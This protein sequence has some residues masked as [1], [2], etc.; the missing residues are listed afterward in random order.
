MF[1]KHYFAKVAVLTYMIYMSIWVIKSNQWA[2]FWVWYCLLYFLSAELTVYF[3]TVLFYFLDKMDDSDLWV[4][5][6]KSIT[7]EIP[8]IFLEKGVFL[9]VLL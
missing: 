5:V 6:L 2:Y 9:L 4:A 1:I 3:Q 8:E 7:E